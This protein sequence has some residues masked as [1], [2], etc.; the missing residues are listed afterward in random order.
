MKITSFARLIVLPLALLS[1]FAFTNVEQRPILGVVEENPGIYAG[2]PNSYGVRVCFTKNGDD[3]KAYP[4]HCKDLECLWK[5]TAQFPRL[6]QWTIVF[7]GKSVG[8]VTG[9]TPDQF[10]F[11]SRIGLQKISGSGAIPSIGKTSAEYAGFAGKPVHR[12]LAANSQP[13][14]KDP[15]RWKSAQPSLLNVGILRRA[16]QKNYPKLCK[17]AGRGELRRELY[18]YREEE[19]RVV[20]IYESRENWILARLHLEDVMDCSDPQAVF[21]MED[22]WFVIDPSH[23]SNYLASGISLIDAGDY[24][25]DGQSEL[26]FSIFRY[27]RGGYQL[28]YDHFKKQATFEYSYH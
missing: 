11:Y 14:F 6:V 4:S 13:Y 3:W 9:E 15:E 7:N 22:A 2:E 24:D 17:K 18:P 8:Q 27:N 5:I 19:I 12:P 21:P 23:Y 25:E 1:A 20:N 26:L 10:L 28:F 16:F